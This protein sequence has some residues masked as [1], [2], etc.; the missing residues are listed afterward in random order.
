MATGYLYEPLP[1]APEGAMRLHLNENTDGCSPVVM[2]AI[3]RITRREITWYP[4]YRSATRAVAAHFGVD[5]DQVL[6]TNGLDEGILTLALAVVPRHG[7][8]TAV[9]VEP[10]Y[11]LYGPVAVLA[12]ATV[13]PAQPNADLSFNR[14]NFRTAMTSDTVLA[15]L[16]NPNNPGGYLIDGPDIAGLADD[17]GPKAVLFVDEAYGDFAG[18]TALP[19]LRTTPTLVIGRT[20]AKAWG[21]AG[22]RIGCLLAAPEMIRRLRGAIAPFSVNVFAAAALEAALADRAH[23]AWYLD[24]VRASKALLY[25]TFDRLGLGYWRTNGNFVLVRVGDA[26]A[27]RQRLA[28]RGVHVRDRS[29]APGCEGCIR[30][31]AGLTEQARFFVSVLEDV[32]CAA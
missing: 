8:S 29:S 19:L 23:F 30:V 11:G 4:E 31:T 3:Q 1:D 28:E 20:F 5:E 10:S 2:E 12:G 9:V 21:L 16:S 26:P 7:R 6:L 15:M 14:A 13:A 27:I 25:E 18:V 32:L 22:M 17:L 24:E